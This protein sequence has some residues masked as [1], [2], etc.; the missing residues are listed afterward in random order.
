MKTNYI[1]LLLGWVIFGASYMFDSPI[2][3]YLSGIGCGLFISSVIL[4]IIEIKNDK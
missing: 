1:F 4:T 2:H 3:G